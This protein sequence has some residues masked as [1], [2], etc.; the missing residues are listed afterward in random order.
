[1]KK[2]F[3]KKIDKVRIDALS[4]IKSILKQRGDNP[5]QLI[6][7]S[8]YEDIR[9]I[10][11]LVYNLPRIG[12]LND[13]GFGEEYPVVSVLLLPNDDLEFE[14]ISCIGDT[15]EDTKFNIDDVDTY[16]ICSIA[17]IISNLEN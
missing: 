3:V 13:D 12:M 14:G 1:M 15:E 16:T 8:T 10:D 17:D 6:D 4:Y 9:D 5:Y 11:D 7:P 2:N